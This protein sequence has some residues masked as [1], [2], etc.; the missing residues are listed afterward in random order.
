MEA[1]TEIEPDLRF[2]AFFSGAYPRLVRAAY[3]LTGSISE[4][5]D[6]AQEAMA[7]VYERW[8]RVGRM[9]SPEGYA[10]RTA[11]NLNRRR[12]RRLM[13]FARRSPS[14]AAAPPDPAAVAEASSD[15]LRAL[16]A[17]PAG[18]RDAL[19]LA[20][21]LGMTPDEVAGLLGI[22]TG[23]VRVRL[24]RARAGFRKQLGEGYE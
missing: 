2:E 9:R 1:V 14:L 16:L 24:H 18:Q 21:F 19:V 22:R 20:E 11:F 3:L 8:E 23:S 13:M 5:E 12:V 6:L 4:A 10:F 15:V 17:L 7:R